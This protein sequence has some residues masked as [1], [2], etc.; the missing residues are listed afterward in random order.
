MTEDHE[1][2]CDCPDCL[3]ILFDQYR[4]QRAEEAKDLAWE[5]TLGG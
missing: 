1:P 4:E 2:E 5:D 3:R